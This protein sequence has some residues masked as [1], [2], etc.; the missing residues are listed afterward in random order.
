[1][2]STFKTLISLFILGFSFNALA[3]SKCEY[4]DTE[5]FETSD[6]DIAWMVLNIGSDDV[7][8]AGEDTDTATF[9]VRKCASNSN[10]VEQM[11][12]STEKVSDRLMLS[13]QSA[14]LQRGGFF[15]WLLGSGGNHYSYFVVEGVIPNAWGVEVD[16]GSGDVEL[17]NIRAL[18]FDV[19]S[20]DLTASHVAMSV[21]GELGSGDVDL[22]HVANVTIAD[23]GSGDM[24]IEHVTGDLLL[25]DIGSGDFE[26]SDLQG[27]L[28]IE[29][30]GS[31]DV[32]VDGVTGSVTV[33]EKGSGDV[34][35][36]NVEGA[37]NIEDWQ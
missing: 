26:V 6:A 27:N 21:L 22:S 25:E 18:K 29:H 36:E 32:D 10:L 33:V 30:L 5:L 17:E 34:D 24:E 1:M 9:T 12:A 37:V 7:S 4:H 3:M 15:K 35:V 28:V 16:L 2:K 23:I 14:T 13:L 8:L 31:G 20:G 19:G 11:Q